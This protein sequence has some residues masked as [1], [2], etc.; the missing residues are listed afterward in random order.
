MERKNLLAAA[1]ILLFVVLVIMAMTEEEQMALAMRLSEESARKEGADTALE[2]AIQLSQESGQ[3]EKA[4]ILKPGIYQEFVDI[5]K[6]FRLGLPAHSET[7]TP[8]K[9][10]QI[11]VRNPQER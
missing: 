7:A 4:A 5:R 10:Y 8:F 11:A 1:S 2:E 6:T 9:V 3:K